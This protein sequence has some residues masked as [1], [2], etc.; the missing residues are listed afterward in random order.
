VVL[1]HILFKSFPH[2]N[3]HKHDDRW[4]E[5][6]RSKFFRHDEQEKY[7]GEMETE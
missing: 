3:G 7:E 5:K 2:H 4:K 1:S 6:F